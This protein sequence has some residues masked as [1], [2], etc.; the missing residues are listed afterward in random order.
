MKEMV[1]H[2][3][4]MQEVTESEKKSEEGKGKGREEK[5]GYFRYFIAGRGFPRVQRCLVSRPTFRAFAILLALLPVPFSLF[6]R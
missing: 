1:S 5:R 6:E 3:T 4:E 2:K